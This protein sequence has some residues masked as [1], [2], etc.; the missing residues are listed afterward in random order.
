M[1]TEKIKFFLIGKQSYQARSSEA[2][3]PILLC[4]HQPDDGQEYSMYMIGMTFVSTSAAS[5]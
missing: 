2:Q 5:C 4:R 3:A 1:E